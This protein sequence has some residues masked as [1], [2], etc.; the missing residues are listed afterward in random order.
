[1]AKLADAVTLLRGCPAHCM[2]STVRM[3]RPVT[4]AE[5]GHLSQSARDA[6]FRSQERCYV[7][8]NCSF[9]YI[10]NASE[11]IPLGHLVYHQEAP[12]WTFE[13]A[14]RPGTPTAP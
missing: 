1:M 12:H 7:C 5:F 2:E 13:A 9:I 11:D 6:V 8:A 4:D 10:R 14:H 3:Q